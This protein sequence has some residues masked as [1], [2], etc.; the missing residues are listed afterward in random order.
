M[1]FGVHHQAFKNKKAVEFVLESFRKY[2]PEDPY[3][4]WSDN[5]DDYSDLCEKYN[6]KYFH[7]DYNVG[8]KHYDKNQVFEL[9]DRIRKTCEFV[10]KKYIVWMEDDVLI[11]GKIEIDDSV[12][13]SG[14]SFTGNY[15]W[16]D[17]FDYLTKKYNIMPNVKW[18]GTAG[19]AVLL[20]EIFL[21]K[22]DVIEKFIENDYEYMTNALWTEMGHPDIM[23]TIAHFLCGKKYSVNTQLTDVNKNPDWRNSNHTLVHSF[24]EFY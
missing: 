24:K 23:I 12:E 3:V 18:F 13:F 6:V 21:E 11:R 19:G 9:F 2:H 4:I 8:I 20:S 17:S 15:F 14:Q 7:S 1:N 16:G 10:N 22:F 5:G